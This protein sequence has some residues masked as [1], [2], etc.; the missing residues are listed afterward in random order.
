MIHGKIQHTLEAILLGITIHWQPLFGIM[1][2]AVAIVYYVAMLK[3]NVVD[4]NHGG[5][6]KRYFKSIFKL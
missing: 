1:A 5:S 6:W 2:S 4:K 3:M